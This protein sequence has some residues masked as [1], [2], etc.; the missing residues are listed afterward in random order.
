MRINLPHCGELNISHPSEKDDIKSDHIKGHVHFVLFREFE[1]K[2][3]FI[4][5]FFQGLN[6]TSDFEKFRGI[7]T[8]IRKGR[9]SRIEGERTIFFVNE[10]KF[11]EKLKNYFDKVENID[12]FVII[13][14]CLSNFNKK[15][16]YKINNEKINESIYKYYKPDFDRMDCSQ[17]SFNVEKINE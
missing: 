16:A 14:S 5:N 8:Y 11:P 3:V 9:H 13:E 6:E 12:D 7:I 2:F 17:F 15:N 1:N 10:Q 4:I